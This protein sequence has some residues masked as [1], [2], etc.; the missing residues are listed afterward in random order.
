MT[1]SQKLNVMVREMANKQTDDTKRAMYACSSKACCYQSE[2]WYQLRIL[3]INSG[4]SP[5]TLRVSLRK[6]DTFFGGCL[7]QYQGLIPMRVKEF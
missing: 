2:F 5:D 7:Y 1:K 3:S 4:F 6:P